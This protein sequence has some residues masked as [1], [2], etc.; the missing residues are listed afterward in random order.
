MKGYAIN[1]VGQQVLTN[2]ILGKQGYMVSWNFYKNHEM[3]HVHIYNV[4]VKK[5]DINKQIGILILIKWSNAQLIN[6]VINKTFDTVER[7]HNT[8]RYEKG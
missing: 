1:T 3:C 5:Y 8:L 4:K 2:R 7:V 6:E